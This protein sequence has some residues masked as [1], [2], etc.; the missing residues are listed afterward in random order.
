MKKANISDSEV[1]HVK[2]LTVFRHKE[3]HANRATNAKY[4][5]NKNNSQV[6]FNQTLPLELVCP[7]RCKPVIHNRLFPHLP[8]HQ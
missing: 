4:F 3:C 2:K 7:D 6:Y 1:W 5:R 8:S